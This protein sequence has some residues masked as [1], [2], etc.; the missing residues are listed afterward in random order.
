MQSYY[1]SQ[2][3]VA[4]ELFHK[5]QYDMVLSILNHELPKIEEEGNYKALCEYLNLKIACLMNKGDINSVEPL[6]E[7]FKYALTVSGNKELQ[8]NHTYHSAN[9]FYFSGDFERSIEYN[10]KAL[11]M[12]GNQ[13]SHPL[14]VGICIN[15]ISRYLEKKDFEKADYY[16]KKIYPL[17]SSIKHESPLTYFYYMNTCAYYLFEQERYD[18]AYEVLN[19]VLMHPLL[20]DN[21]K[22]YAMT[23]I[24]I[25]AYYTR[26][27][28]FEKANDSFKQGWAIIEK[29]SDL[30]LKTHFLTPVI[31][32]YE[33]MSDYKNAYEFSRIK[34]DLLESEES[35]RQLERLHE[36]ALRSSTD[37][38]NVLAYTDKLT[39]LYNRHYF[40]EEAEKWLQEA[41][42]DKTPLCCALFDIDNFKEINNQYGHVMGDQILRQT[43]EV[44]KKFDCENELFISRYGGDE[45][46]IFSKNVELF[47]QTIEHLFHALHAVEIPYEDTY[48]SFTI[49]LGA[50]VIEDLSDYTVSM[51]VQKAD[52]QLYEVK[53]SGKNN[54][55]FAY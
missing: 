24:N 11:E 39:R 41:I 52:E 35:R 45:F 10:L 34:N 3:E 2:L 49:S 4:R 31:E 30:T 54:V 18:E 19:D 50:V 22:Q 25:G 8:V 53:R 28:Q 55:K 43:G 14:Y 5:T 51:I 23:I 6:L 36:F 32:R 40:E 26:T 12:L 42:D 29:T 20:K 47:K 1:D 9:L 13:H 7:K 38:L 15:L 27:K 33:E 21:T 46:T 48:I 37:S 17:M 16:S 44:L